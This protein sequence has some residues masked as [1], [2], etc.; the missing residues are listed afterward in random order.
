M[1][2][3]L[4]SPV[5]ASR[6]PTASRA[7]GFGAKSVESARGDSEVVAALELSVLTGA[8]EGYM[9][10]QRGMF[11]IWQW[12]TLSQKNRTRTV[13]DL[14]ARRLSEQNAAWM[15]KT[16]SE[17]SEQVRQAIRLA[18]QAQGFPRDEF[19][20]LDCSQKKCTN[21]ARITRT[22]VSQMMSIRLHYS[23]R[24]CLD[25]C[26]PNGSRAWFSADQATSKILVVGVQ[27][28]ADFALQMRMVIVTLMAFLSVGMARSKCFRSGLN[29]VRPAGTA[30]VIDPLTDNSRSQQKPKAGLRC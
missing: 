7:A 22:A 24:D 20:G 26:G 4:N 6:R 17:K 29:N 30:P 23:V 27:A 28:L 11:G 2:A 14:V 18:L 1:P 19:P 25:A 5:P 13:V 9:V 15:R 3:K 10:S 8:N 12:E 16:L 21:L